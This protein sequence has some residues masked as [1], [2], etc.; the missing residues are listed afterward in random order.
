MTADTFVGMRYGV[1]VAPCTD[2]V[3]ASGWEAAIDTR[4]RSGPEKLL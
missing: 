2:P 4:V 1:N 3:T